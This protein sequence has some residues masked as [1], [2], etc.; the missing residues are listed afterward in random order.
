MGREFSISVAL[1]YE[2]SRVCCRSNWPRRRI[3]TW[4]GYEVHHNQK[5]DAPGGTALQLAN[6]VIKNFPR[7][8]KIVSLNPIG[9][10]APNELTCPPFEWASSLALTR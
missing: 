5:A 10:V 7:K 6:E 9:K 1:F 4:G 3:L 2:N 8:N